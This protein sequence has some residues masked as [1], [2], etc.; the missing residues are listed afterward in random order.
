MQNL[1]DD[2]LAAV[3][4]ITVATADLEFLLARIGADQAGGDAGAV[5]ARP[6][7]PVRAA[8]GSVEFAPAEFRDAFVAAVTAAGDLLTEAR[9][10][11][12]AMWVG[13]AAGWHVLNRPVA[14]RQPADPARLDALAMRLL[15]CR[16][17]LDVL[18]Q[19]RL[20]TGA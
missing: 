4:R 5:Y 18:V 7:E 16:A 17:G 13:G 3:G 19:A 12:H 6:G 9:A 20:R 10:A 8:R 14:I 2:V 1:P 15:V 11:V